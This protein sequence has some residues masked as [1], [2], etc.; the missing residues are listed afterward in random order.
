MECMN[1]AIQNMLRVLEEKEKNNWSVHVGG[2]LMA[3]NSILNM[4]SLDS[5]NISWYG[6]EKVF[7]LQTFY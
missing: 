3:Y 4:L 5:H 7:Y 6:E 1:M 2:L